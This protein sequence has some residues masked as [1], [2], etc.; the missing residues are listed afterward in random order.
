MK[1]IVITALMLATALAPGGLYRVRAAEAPQ[2]SRDQL[3]ELI[4]TARTP[5]DHEKIAR[6]YRAEADRLE[7]EA[8]EHEELAAIYRRKKDA[9]AE[10]HPMSGRTAA[11]CDYFAKS[12]REAAKA[13]RQLA[14]DHESMAKQARR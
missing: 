11:H 8:T 13:D 5:D 7:A 12:M 14:A 4:S 3:K 6:Y 1:K 10:K 9:I 2:I